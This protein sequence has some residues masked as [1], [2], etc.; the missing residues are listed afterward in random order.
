MGKAR[1]HA[2]L[3]QARLA[4]APLVDEEHR[5]LPTPVDITGVDFV[6]ARQALPV[7]KVAEIIGRTKGVVISM[8]YTGWSPLDAAQKRPRITKHYELTVWSRPLVLES[9]EEAKADGALYADDV[10]DSVIIRL[11]KWRP[12]EDHVNGEVEMKG[13][14][15]VPDKRFLLYSGEISI[16]AFL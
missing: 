3:I 1:T 9:G 12:E 10:M 4:T 14:D 6:Y 7:D 16:P 15:Q 8:T 13:G 5:E 2:A 11:W